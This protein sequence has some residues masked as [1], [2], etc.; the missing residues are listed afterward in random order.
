MTIIT[1]NAIPDSTITPVGPFCSNDAAVNLTA[2]TSGGTWKVDAT[3]LGS[4][5]F[6][7]ASYSVGS[8]QIH[9]N[10]TAGGCSS[11]DTITVQIN[12]RKNATITAVAAMCKNAAVKT[13]TAVDAGGV[14]SGTGITNTSTGIFN[15]STSG[16]G[17]FTITYT[18]AGS[19]GDTKTTSITV[20]PIDS[21]KI[22]PAGPFC[23]QSSATTLQLTSG[24]TTGGVWSGTGVTSNAGVGTFDPTGLPQGNHQIKYTSP[25][26]CKVS[27][28]I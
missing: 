3:T 25:G 8:H 15:P 6:N 11:H 10:V 20:N 23:S 4:N 18:I 27:D 16:A 24:S 14:W 5:S 21:A 17:T 2:A 12:Q 19:C 22:L 28:S 7:P 1:V 26:S 13:L 9:Y